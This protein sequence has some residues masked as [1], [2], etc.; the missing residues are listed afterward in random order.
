VGYLAVPAT[1]AVARVREFSG[2]HC[3]ARNSQRI[4]ISRRQTHLP[5]RITR[6]EFDLAHMA[7]CYRAQDAGSVTLFETRSI[8]SYP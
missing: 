1:L 7:S 6:A 3:D 5:V 4:T 2:K 8:A